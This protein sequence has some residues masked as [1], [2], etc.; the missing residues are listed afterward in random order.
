MPKCLYPDC[1]GDVEPGAPFCEDCG[2][3]QAPAQVAAATAGAQFR[4]QTP[5]A[6]FASPMPATLPRPPPAPPAVLPRPPSPVFAGTAIPLP[7]AVGFG[8]LLLLLFLGCMGALAIGIVM[9]PLVQLPP[10]STP[11][12]VP[13]GRVG[14]AE[15]RVLVPYAGW[16]GAS[17]GATGAASGRQ[18]VT[19]VPV[20]GRLSSR[21]L[22][23]WAP[24]I[25]R[26]IASPRPL[27]PA[28]KGPA[29]ALAV[30]AGGASFPW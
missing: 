2:R 3:S 18:T 17:A 28:A 24:T 29:S 9:S 27:W 13:G 1:D 25:S 4:L 6:G 5:A 7:L 30:R 15:A 10:Q 26:T 21:T 22:P 16:P 20:P 19:V 23:P 12:A 14:P 8:L 11:R